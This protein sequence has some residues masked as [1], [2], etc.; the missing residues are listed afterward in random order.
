VSLERALSHYGLILEAV[1]LV[2]SVIAGRPVTLHTPVGTFR[3]RHVRTAWFS[4]FAEVD[5]GGDPAFMA[6]PEKALL[7][8][9]HLTPGEPTAARLE[10]LRLQNLAR[11]GRGFGRAP[12]TSVRAAQ[13]EC[14]AFDP[15]RS[16][17]GGAPHD[18]VK[19]SASVEEKYR[20]RGTVVP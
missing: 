9:L 3:Y 19:L 1:V 16:V 12:R 11:F 7:D 18:V 8:L 13:G 20:F 4:D 10:A 14:I 17:S 15:L 6:S 2:Q 5:A